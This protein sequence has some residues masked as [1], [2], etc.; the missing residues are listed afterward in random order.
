[1]AERGEYGHV[2]VG[3]DIM[4]EEIRYSVYGYG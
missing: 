3:D 2:L 1:M 4:A